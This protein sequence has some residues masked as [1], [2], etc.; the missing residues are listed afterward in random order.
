MGQMSVSRWPDFKI[1]ILSLL[2]M[3]NSL[4][5]P[6]CALPP[7][8]ASWRSLVSRSIAAWDGLATTDQTSYKNIHLPKSILE[9][10]H[11]LDDFFNKNS[12][13]LMFW[14]FQ[15]RSAFMSQNRI[16][17][18]SC[19]ELDDYVLLPASPGFVSRRDCF[20][21]SH[22]WCTQ[23]NPDPNGKC[24]RLH[25]AELKPQTWSYIW[26]DRTCLP[27]SPRAPQEQEY[28]RRCLKTISGIIRNCGFIYFYPSFEPRF[29]I[30]CEITEYV[31]TCD[32]GI[33]ITSDIKPYLQHVDEMLET[34]VQATLKKHSYRCSN[35]SDRQYLTPWPE[36]PVLLRRL[37]HVED[38]RKIMDD[39]TWL[40]LVQV[41][42]YSGVEL[43]LNR[44]EGTLIVNGKTHTF[45]PFPR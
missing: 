43:E 19:N 15:K 27:Q 8:L 6:S 25:Q 31:L 34:G 23:D 28:F 37:V 30:L 18:W 9:E 22:F 16:K 13:P 29:W 38:I 33:L 39:M 36:L 11:C 45:A 12:D 35:G 4:E 3:S 7:H 44:F 17:R 20:F 10:C 26:V 14:F 41:Q 40:D 2:A 42:I 5:A 32:G 24:L 21:V 1:I